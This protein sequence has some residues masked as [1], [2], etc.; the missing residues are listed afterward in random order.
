LKEEEVKEEM[1][2]RGESKSGDKELVKYIGI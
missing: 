2:E 1:Q